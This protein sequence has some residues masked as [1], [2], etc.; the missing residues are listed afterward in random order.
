MIWFYKYN[1]FQSSQQTIKLGS[2]YH[3]EALDL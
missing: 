2:H 1:E 3:G